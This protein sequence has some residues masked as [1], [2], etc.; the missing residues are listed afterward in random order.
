M[1][2]PAKE[3]GP[4]TRRNVVR[5]NKK[6]AGPNPINAGVTVYQHKEIICKDGKVGIVKSG[7]GWDKI[8]KV[9]TKK[10]IFHP[11]GGEG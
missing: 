2:S 5:G 10:T 9:I 7:K 8:N 3:S 6:F 4:D 1:K 11:L